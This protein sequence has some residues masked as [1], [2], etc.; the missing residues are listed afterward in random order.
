MSVTVAAGL[1]QKDLMEFCVANNVTLTSVPVRD[2]DTI[3]GQIGTGSH[4]SSII[5]KRNVLMWIGQ[6][7]Q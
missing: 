7:R 4:V 1:S 3:A 2:S 5:Q 6:L